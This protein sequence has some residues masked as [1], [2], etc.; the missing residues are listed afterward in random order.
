MNTHT[1]TITDRNT[2]Q[3]VE[4]VKN[5]RI[6]DRMRISGQYKT[7][8]GM[9]KYSITETTQRFDALGYPAG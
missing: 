5:A 6:P 8:G 4:I 3:I 1:I 7:W 2:N 9:E